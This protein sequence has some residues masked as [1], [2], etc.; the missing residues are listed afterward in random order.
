M[1]NDIQLRKDFYSLTLST[2]GR[3]KG[4]GK[5]NNTGEKSSKE[6]VFFELN[7]KLET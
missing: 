4:E 3:G 1:V 2:L 7:L 6:S 5:D